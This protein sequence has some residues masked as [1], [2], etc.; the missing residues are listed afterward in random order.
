M[1]IGEDCEVEVY[2]SYETLPGDAVAYDENLD[3]VNW[4]L[5]QDYVGQPSPGCGGSYTFGDVQMAI[6]DFIAVNNP[7]YPDQLG[8]WSSCRVEE[9]K[10]AASAN[11]EGYIPGCG[12]LVA[13]ILYA[14]SGA[15]PR[16]QNSLI[17]IPMPC[18]ECETAWGDGVLFVEKTNGR[19]GMGSWAMYMVLYRMESNE[20]KS[21]SE[22]PVQFLFSKIA[23][24]LEQI[25]IIYSKQ[26]LIV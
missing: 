8:P 10:D 2:S 15:R 16:A 25:K 13:V 19:V 9:I 17:T 6:W 4:I 7:P 11:G 21:I 26:N 1:P 14:A 23:S 24:F 20:D 5:N 18:D 12:E 22:D 3:L